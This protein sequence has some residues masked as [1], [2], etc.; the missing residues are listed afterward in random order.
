MPKTEMPG[1]GK[2]A[3]VYTGIRR[4]AGG[5]LRRRP[6]CGGVATLWSLPRLPLRRFDTVLRSVLAQWA[7]NPVNRLLRVGGWEMLPSPKR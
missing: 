1:M 4:T 3:R 5:A 2:R 6:L 7:H